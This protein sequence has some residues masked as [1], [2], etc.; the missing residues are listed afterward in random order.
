MKYTVEYTKAAFK[1]L[2]KMDKKITAF[3]LSYIEEKLIYCD[4]P[5]IYGK[6][7]QGNLND[8]WRYLA[9][10]W[11]IMIVVHAINKAAIN[12]KKPPLSSIDSP[13]LITIN[14]PMKPAMTADQRCSPTFSPSSSTDRIV[15]KIGVVCRIE[16]AS[17]S[18][19]SE[20]A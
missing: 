2:K 19:I 16:I 12:M 10:R 18:F 11:R 1:Q 14:M 3:I 13:G 7:L 20:N 8:K 9:L 17:A 5:R 4:N 6:A 15:M